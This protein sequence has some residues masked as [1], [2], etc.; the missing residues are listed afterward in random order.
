MEYEYWFAAEFPVSAA[1]KREIAQGGYTAETVYRIRGK[2]RM[3][4][5][6]YFD[7]K[8]E[9]LINAQMKTDMSTRLKEMEKRGIAIVPFDDKKYPAKLRLIRN[10]P[11]ALFVMGSLPG[12]T[13]SVGI[14]GARRCSEYGR[15][16]AGQIAQALALNG[17]T[18]VSGLASGIDSAGH[19]GALKGG[20]HTYAVLGCGP[21]ICYPAGSRQL[22][23]NILEA[24]GGILSE[25]PPG[26]HPMPAF[27]PER[28]RIIS[29]L[30]DILI[31]AEAK[32]RSGSLITADFAL[33]QG[34]E[35]CAV[36]GRI[37]DPCSE[38]CNHLIE[39][40]AAILYNIEKFL[41][42][43]NLK[44]KNCE[45]ISKCARLGLEKDEQ[46]LYSCLDLEP[47]FID[48]IIEETGF[49]FPQVI[50]LLNRLKRQGLVRE[51]FKNYFSRCTF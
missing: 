37:S 41:Q 17:V 40:G 39:Q 44:C 14:V 50:H 8:E 6:A 2:E 32:K 27:F 19:A 12:N 51:T 28:N 24:D 9:I 16:A 43:Y 47:K 46:L 25:Y 36:P 20:G 26:M 13:V 4:F 31:V 42:D 30:S 34:K 21:D 18:V 45:N 1:K 33:E 7:I 48:I 22:Y 29:G 3:M 38:G 35:V 11:R 15:T 5:C 10:P 49:S 23:E